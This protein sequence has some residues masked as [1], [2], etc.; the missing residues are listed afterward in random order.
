MYK[1]EG[2]QIFGL[3]NEQTVV[4]PFERALIYMG[5]S[6]QQNDWH[7]NLAMPWLE[8]I[9]D[10]YFVPIFGVPSNVPVTVPTF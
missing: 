10:T 2:V 8:S 1:S 5:L 6:M 7:D 4:D 3:P 9:S